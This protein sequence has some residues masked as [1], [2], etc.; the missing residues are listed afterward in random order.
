MINRTIEKQAHWCRMQTM[1][2]RSYETIRIR[3]HFYD[4][5]FALILIVS[6]YAWL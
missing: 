4:A 1:R 6:R 5:I 2:P 3:S